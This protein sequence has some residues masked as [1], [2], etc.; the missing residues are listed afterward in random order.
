MTEFLARYGAKVYYIKSWQKLCN[1][2]AENKQPARE[3]RTAKS[4]AT[5]TTSRHH[6][7]THWLHAQNNNESCNPNMVMC[8]GNARHERMTDSRS[9]Q[10][11]KV[12]TTSEADGVADNTEYAEIY[13]DIESADTHT[14]TASTT[15]HATLCVWCYTV[16][17][18]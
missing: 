2:N 16:L 9:R 10:P 1:N 17:V 18:L 13:R 3:S 8:R 12:T 4:R 15:K 6:Y 14:N 5:V 11:S 7:Y